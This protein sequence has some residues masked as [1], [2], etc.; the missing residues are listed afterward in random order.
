MTRRTAQHGL[1]RATIWLVAVSLSFPSLAPAS[2]G[3]QAASGDTSDISCCSAK[4]PASAS[5]EDSGCCRTP[6]STCKHCC[7]DRVSAKSSCCHSQTDGAGSLNGKCTCG[8]SCSCG[9]GPV[10]EPPAVPASQEQTPREQVT[11]AQ[12]GL[13]TCLPSDGAVS[14]GNSAGEIC[15]FA[16]P[17]TSSERCS[18]LSR[19]T[20]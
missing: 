1:T 4:R 20:L 13:A 11:A 3:C 10:P 5:I 6:E 18:L 16:G 7:H 19:F 8:A 9:R 15:E 2:C 14:N 17:A 12:V